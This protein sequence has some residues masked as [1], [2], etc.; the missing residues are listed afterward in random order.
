MAVGIQIP[1]ALVS[2]GWGTPT[3]CVRHGESATRHE[4]VRF[5]SATSS[6]TYLTL[7]AGVLLF[8]IVSAVMRKRVAAAS[9]PFCARCAEKRKILLQVGLGMIAGGIAVGLLLGAVLPADQTG[10]AVL[11]AVVVAV[12]GLI[13]VSRTGWTVVAD[14]QV[15]PDGQA[16]EFR[17]AHETFASQAAASQQAAAQYY[18]AQQ[19]AY[20]QQFHA[21]GQPLQ[22]QA[23]QGQPFSA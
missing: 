22:G 16:V 9:W 3:V 17:R 6:W 8:I 5:L 4:R 21:A 12:A 18:A 23:L 13:V 2:S 19:Q 20:A 11:L 15:V 14:G 1:V 7:L 10:L